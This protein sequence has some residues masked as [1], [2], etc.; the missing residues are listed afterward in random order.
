MDS[1]AETG[2]GRAGPESLM[3]NRYGRSDPTA[4]EAPPIPEALGLN[5]KTLAEP[6][7]THYV[8]EPTP[9]GPPKCEDAKAPGKRSVGLERLWTGASIVN[10]AENRSV[11]RCI[12][13]FPFFA[14]VRV[15][16]EREAGARLR[17]KAGRYAPPNGT[18]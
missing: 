1:S 5:I 17:M 15:C 3:Q 14:A 16:F 9:A 13:M 12:H 10:E 7:I 4:N 6:A 18:A 8:E 11:N 2:P